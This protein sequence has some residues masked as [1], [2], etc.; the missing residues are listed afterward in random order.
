MSEI[1]FIEGVS[2]V[3]KSTM[4]DSLAFAL[5]A[6]GYQV[7]SYLEFD[8][9][10]PIDFYSTAYFRNNEY[11]RFCAHYEKH[12]SLI[13]QY[14]IPAG[15][16]TLVRYYDQNTPL[17]DEPLL[18][19]LELYEFCYKPTRVI[20]FQEYTD[21]YEHIWKR[22]AHSLDRETDYYL[23]DGSLLHHP[24]NDMIR[25]YDVDVLQAGLHVKSM[26]NAI[27]AIKYHV[28]YLYTNDISRRL[29]QAHKSRNQKRPSGDKIE[30]WKKR[31]AYDQ[32]I[33]DKYIGKYT[34]IDVSESGWNSAMNRIILS[35]G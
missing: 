1:I 18:S 30:F 25:N 3:G 5:R 31:Y 19:E 33:L 23:F 10:N 17:F 35:L 16:A 22:F 9:A 15:N 14:S 29:I 7:R 24:L 11:N 2:G 32:L 13:K 26:L 8:F 28:F 20:P 4:V 27:S 34:S 12:L 6:K 21:T